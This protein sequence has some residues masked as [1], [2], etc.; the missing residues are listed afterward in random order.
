[1]AK[2][3]LDLLNIEELALL[4]DRAIEKLA[5]KVGARQAELEAEME[6]L[7]QYGKPAK[8]ALASAPLATKPKKRDEKRGDEAKNDATG[9]EVTEPIADAA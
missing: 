1:M 3:D 4:R 9:D 5:E 2:I 6:R 7:S 8:K